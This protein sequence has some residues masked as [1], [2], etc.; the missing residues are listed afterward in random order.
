MAKHFAAPTLCIDSSDNTFSI[1]EMEPFTIGIQ[2]H[3]ASFYENIYF[4][5]TPT[6]PTSLTFGMWVSLNETRYSMRG[7]PSRIV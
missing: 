2:L 4:F 7:Y 6:A 1:L 3:F 5:F